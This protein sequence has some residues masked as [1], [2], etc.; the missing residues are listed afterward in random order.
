M[1]FAAPRIDVALRAIKRSIICYLGLT[2]MVG[3]HHT[4]G[5]TPGVITSPG[6]PWS[7]WILFDQ[8][9]EKIPLGGAWDLKSDMVTDCYKLDTGSGQTV[10]GSAADVYKVSW[11][12]KS[13]KSLA[14][15][16]AGLL[17]IGHSVSESQS[18]SIEFDTTFTTTAINEVP[19]PK[20][21]DLA[22]DGLPR[23]PGI[24]A[25]FGA[26]RFT[27]SL[28]DAHGH[29]LN[30]NAETELKSASVSG[31][32]AFSSGTTSETDVSFGTTRLIGA[33]Y[34]AYES[35]GAPKI[36]VTDAVSLGTPTVLTNL[37]W[38]IVVTQSSQSGH[39]RVAMTSLAGNS[40]G[41]P[42]TLDG[43]L[44]EG[45]FPVGREASA[46]VQG[47]FVWAELWI[48]PSTNDYKLELFQQNYRKLSWAAADD[49]DSLLAW[50]QRRASK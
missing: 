33:H 8:P 12:S 30:A 22:R 46:P 6:T 2:V 3:C 18:G 35:D 40:D 34:V 50:I 25:L 47:A 1:S 32:L 45:T 21:A 41:L 23:L 4:N 17:G 31:T 36:T 20:C 24:A 5:G 49:E 9:E 15:K 48:G 37:G 7:T 19:D 16:I 42:I 10:G 44:D 11:T 38:Q 13:D 27:Y 28:R 26:T 29:N 39:Y 43:L 14:L